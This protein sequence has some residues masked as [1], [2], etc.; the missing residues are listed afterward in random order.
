MEP[1]ES[2][3]LYQHDS[4][5]NK[6][7]DVH[8]EKEDDNSIVFLYFKPLYKDNGWQSLDK[9]TLLKQIRQSDDSYNIIDVKMI[10]KDIAN[11]CKRVKNKEIKAMLNEKCDKFATKAPFFVIKLG[12]HCNHCCNNEHDNMK[13]ANSKSIKTVIKLIS[14]K[15]SL[16]KQQR[17][18][19]HCGKGDREIRNKLHSNAITRPDRWRRMD[20]YCLKMLIKQREINKIQRY[21]KKMVELEYTNKKAVHLKRDKRRKPWKKYNQNAKPKKKYN[22]KWMLCTPVIDFK[23]THIDA[24]HEKVQVIGNN[25]DDHDDT[26]FNNTCEKNDGNKR[27]DERKRKPSKSKKTKKSKKSK[28]SNKGENGKSNG[29]RKTEAKRGQTKKRKKKQGKVKGKRNNKQRKGRKKHND[30]IRRMIL[31]SIATTRHVAL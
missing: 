20:I 1:T 29:R 14:R 4:Y 6:Y 25:Y 24:R 17:R 3:S 27:K 10:Y 13:C 16:S 26:I 19:L 5:V 12:E 28:N 18:R 9:R 21:N 7:F 15:V 22:R 8:F 23:F 11:C 30:K 31:N 2:K